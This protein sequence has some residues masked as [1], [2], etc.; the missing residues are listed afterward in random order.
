MLGLVRTVALNPAVRFLENISTIALLYVEVVRV[1]EQEAGG[2]TRT[3]LGGR[4]IGTAFRTTSRGA[5]TNWEERTPVAHLAS[6]SYATIASKR[7]PEIR[8]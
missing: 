4:V 2:A 5:L 1:M 3:P 8:V 6:G 7:N